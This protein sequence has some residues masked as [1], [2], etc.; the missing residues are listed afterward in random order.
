M[1]AYRSVEGALF[2]QQALVSY[3]SGFM[4]VAVCTLICIP[5]VLMLRHKKTEKAIVPAEH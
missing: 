5:V 4:I 1:L 2:R 3:D